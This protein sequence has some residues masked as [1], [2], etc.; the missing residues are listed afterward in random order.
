MVRNLTVALFL[1]T[2]F[3]GSTIAQDTGEEEFSPYN[4]RHQIGG[5]LGTWVNAGEDPPELL[6]DGLN[7]LE[8]NISSVNVYF[9]GYFAYNLFPQTFLELSVGI[10]NRGSVT[11][12]EGVFTDIGNL[13]I[14]PFLL[15]L[16]Y[17]PFSIPNSRLHP[18]VAV[19]G[20][21]YY[22]RQDIQFTTGDPFFADINA[23]SETDFNYTISGGADW[24]LGD[25]VALEINA[26]YMPINFSQSLVTIRDYDGFAITIGA[27]YLYG[28]K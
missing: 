20:G 15:Q 27:K 10:V 23:D 2:M 7:I 12:Q 1:L 11:V 8:T 14:Y 5:R 17:Y 3:V 13:L 28:T 25:K 22:G 21:L 4:N 26:K 9:E 16:K 24:L 19:G 18:Y 6:S